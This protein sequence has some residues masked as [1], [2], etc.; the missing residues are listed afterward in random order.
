MTSHYRDRNRPASAFQEFMGI[1]DEQWAS[2]FDEISNQYSGPF[3]P[4]DPLEFFAGGDIA[5]VS[6]KEV[7]DVPKVANAHP[8]S[9]YAG[10]APLVPGGIMLDLKRMK[11]ILGVGCGYFSDHFSSYC[12]LEVVLSD[13]KLLRI[14]MGTMDNNALWHLFNYGFGTPDDEGVVNGQGVVYNNPGLYIT[15]ASVLPA[16]TGGPTT[17]SI[18]ALSS[19]VAE[20]LI[21]SSSNQPPK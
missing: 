1:V 17:F 5:P 4:G 11:R 16:A 13:G 18:A 15:D 7:Q 14:G 3:N 12:G 10:A 6:V 19:C 21:K 9:L 2:G 20:Q 8:V